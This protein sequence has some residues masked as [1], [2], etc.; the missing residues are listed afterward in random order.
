MKQLGWWMQRVLW[1]ITKETSTRD[2]VTI[3]GNAV[4]YNNTIFSF[5]NLLSIT[6]AIYV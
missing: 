3:Y 2:K 4:V 1:W 6:A 5:Y